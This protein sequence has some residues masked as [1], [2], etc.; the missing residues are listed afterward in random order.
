MLTKTTLTGA[1]HAQN[2]VPETCTSS[3]SL[4]DDRAMIS[5]TWAVVHCPVVDGS[6]PDDG[7]SNYT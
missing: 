4:K 3:V 7:P 1:T 6:R 2:M 5:L